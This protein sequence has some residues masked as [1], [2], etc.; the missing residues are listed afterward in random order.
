MYSDR[1][2]LIKPKHVAVDIYIYIKLCLDLFF[3]SFINKIHPRIGHED[4]EGS[5]GIAVLFL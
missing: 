4:P 3:I 5:R 2:W 1:R